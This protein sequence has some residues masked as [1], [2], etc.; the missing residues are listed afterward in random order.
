MGIGHYLF[1]FSGRINRAKMW[2]YLL[3]V[4]LYICA[5]VAAVVATIGAQNI[6]AAFQGKAE[7]PTLFANPALPPVFGLLGLVDL[8][9]IWIALAVTTKRLHDRNKSAWWLLVFV[10]LPFVLGI[11]RFAL[12]IG[13]MHHGAPFVMMN[14]PAATLLGGA[15]AII[16]LW[17]FVELYILRGTEGDNRYGPDPL[18]G[19]S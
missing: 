17:A 7:F 14:N 5:A 2:L 9:F 16:Q 12:V 1:S 4:V 19:K 11:A 3:L 10:G 6:A 18:A 15:S 8:A 13:G